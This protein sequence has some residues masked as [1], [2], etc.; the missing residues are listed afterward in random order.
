M[1]LVKLPVN[2]KLLVIKFLQNKL[3]VDF[4]LHGKGRGPVPLTQRCSRVNN[5]GNNVA[6]TFKDCAVAIYI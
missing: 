2:S 4:Q 3:Y 5:I 1:L 6:S